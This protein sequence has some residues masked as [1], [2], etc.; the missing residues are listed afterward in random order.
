MNTRCDSII[1]GTPVPSH[2]LCNRPKYDA[3][4]FVLRAS[5]AAP[6]STMQMRKQRQH[7]GLQ[8]AKMLHDSG[9]C[10]C[11]CLA[12][13]SDCL[14]GCPSSTSSVLLSTSGLMICLVDTWSL[15]RSSSST[16]R[17]NPCVDLE[18][19]AARRR[20]SS[21]PQEVCS[22]TIA[23]PTPRFWK[24]SSLVP[25]HTIHQSTFEVDQQARHTSSSRRSARWCFLSHCEHPLRCEADGADA[26]H[27]APPTLPAKEVGGFRLPVS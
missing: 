6:T 27:D 4:R 10:L 22:I 12:R 5:A 7:P 11:A 9:K 1:C 8:K 17:R 15:S 25:A 23:F 20:V 19:A 13:R 14:A 21:V 26:P 2:A 24:H 18:A 16:R 3:P